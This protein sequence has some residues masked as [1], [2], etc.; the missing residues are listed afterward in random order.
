MLQCRVVEV[1]MKADARQRLSGC[2]QNGGAD[3]AIYEM[4]LSNKLPANRRIAIFD[5]QIKN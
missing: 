5:H 3:S 1:P 4:T 2:A